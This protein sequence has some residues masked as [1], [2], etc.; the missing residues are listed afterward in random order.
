MV[1]V[2]DLEE[3]V[4]YGGVV[5]EKIIW[6]GVGEGVVTFHSIESSFEL[7]VEWG[8]MQSRN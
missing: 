2:R 3:E 4:G 6:A 7:S 8:R 5:G 1:G